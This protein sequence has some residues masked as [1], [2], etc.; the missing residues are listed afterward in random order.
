MIYYPLRK[1]FYTL[2]WCSDMQPSYSE[3]LFIFDNFRHPVYRT[4]SH[5]SEMKWN[6]TRAEATFFC[7]VPKRHPLREDFHTLL[8]QSRNIEHFQYTETTK[9][10]LLCMDIVSYCVTVKCWS[11]L[12]FVSLRILTNSQTHK[13]TSAKKRWFIRLFYM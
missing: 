6:D 3:R 2:M 4:L 5:F 1:C 12:C 11:D 8:W 10:I 9:F 7:N 13:L